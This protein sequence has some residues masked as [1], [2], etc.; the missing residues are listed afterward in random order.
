MNTAGILII[1]NEILDGVTLNTNSQWIINHLKPLNVNVKETIT[2]RDDTSEIARAI[3]RLL[4]D[5]CTTVF[6]TGGLGPTYDDMTLLGVA[7]AFTLPMEQNEEALTIVTR[8][9]RALHAKGIIDSPEITEPRRK[10]AVFPRGAT[11]L[12]NRAGGAPGVLLKRGGASIISLPGVPSELEWIFDNQVTPLLR[13]S[14]EGVYIEKIINLPLRDESTLA[15]IIEEAMR[16]APDVYIKSMVK[17]YGEKGIRLWVSA[18]GDAKE[19][20]EERVER[21]ATLL[22]RL[23]EERLPGG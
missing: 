2:V 11:P 8:Q 21:A 10:M 12:D 23:T 16:E 22:V 18:H 14:A 1:G 5:G 15:P 3:K 6:T 17:P 20:V 7:E 13:R 19:E 9:Y 4:K